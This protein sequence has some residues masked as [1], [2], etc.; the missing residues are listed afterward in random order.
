MLLGAPIAAAF[1]YGGD[2]R[3]LL[4]TTGLFLLTAS[5]AACGN[6]AQTSTSGHGGAGGA[7]ITGGGGTATQ[8]QT[9]TSSGG[10]GMAGAGGATTGGGGA[11]GSGA[12]GGGGAA[13]SGGTGGGWPT[14]E[15]KPA[16][17]PDKT[18]HEI[19]M[20]DPVSPTQVWVSGAY[21]TAVSQNGCVADQ[22]CQ[23]F[24]QEAPQFLDLADA[25]QRSLKVFASA[26]TAVHFVGIA[27]GDKVDVQAWA[28]RYNVDGQNE[29]LLQVNQQLPGCAKKVGQGA[30]VPVSATLADLT[31][32]SY[33][34]DRGPVF[35]KVDGVSGKPHLPAETFGLW[36]TGKID[37]S[38]DGPTSLSPFFLDGAA[39]TG[40]TAEKIHDFTSVTGVFGLF[41]PPADPLVKYKEIYPRT[42]ADVVIKKV[43]P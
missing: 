33:E 17:V 4:S 11:A 10:G 6:S 26:P 1:D 39:F 16:D 31:I 34:V 42:M 43:N 8:T 25:S 14:C 24:V 7:T 12:T 29:L 23:F 20:E 15:A 35:V 27:V 36:T 37:M 5:I 2:M 40:L 32:Q 30:P 18:L 21:V 28:W 22:A 13:G 9:S 3:P 41:V 38:P 19:W